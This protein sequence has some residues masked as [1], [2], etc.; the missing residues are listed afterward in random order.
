MQPTVTGSKSSTRH[1]ADSSAPPERH[2]NLFP[3]ASTTPVEDPASE[4]PP[5]EPNIGIE[6]SRY[7]RPEV[8]QHHELEDEAQPAVLAATLRDQ[9]PVGVVQKAELLEVCSR[10][11]L[12]ERE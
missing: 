10:R 2:A 11:R 3:P 8:A 7:E 9:P 6:A 12:K 5:D 4:W 1:S